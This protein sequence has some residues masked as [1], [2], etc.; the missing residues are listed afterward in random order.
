MNKKQLSLG[1]VG[2]VAPALG[3]SVSPFRRFAVSLYVVGLLAA[4]LPAPAQWVTQSISLKSGW[5]AVYLHV[6]P[7]YDTLD[8]QIAADASD[9]IL[10]V[11]LWAPPASTLQFVQSPQQPVE[12]EQWRSWNRNTPAAATLHRLVANAAYLVRSATNYTWTIKGKPLPPAYQWTTTG[13]NF[14]GFPT[15]PSLPPTFDSFLS[16]VPELYQSAEIYQYPGGEL[17]TGNPARLY[18]LRTTKVNRGQAYWIRS[19]TFYNRYFAPFEVVLSGSSGVD[20]GDNLTVFNFRLRNLTSTNLTVNLG[21]LASETPPTGQS[22]IVGT[23][24]L[25]V[26]GAIN[27]TNLTY[28]YSNLTAGGAYNWTLS[29]QGLSGSEVE[30]VLGLNRT[31]LSGS[32]G[33]L[34]AG[35]LRLTDAL[36]YARVDLPVSAQ[37]ASRA[38]LWV[39]EASLSQVGQYLKSYRRDGHS[40]PVADTNG[41]YVVSGINTN[42]GVVPRSFPLRL[43]VHNPEAGAGPAVLL[44]RVF[45]GVDAWTN[46]VVAL[47]ESSLHPNLLKQARRISAAHLPWTETNQCWAFD[48]ALGQ[49]TNLTTTVTLDY[50]DRASNPFLHAYHPDHDNL[51]TAFRNQMPQGAESY[52]VQRQ[53]TLTVTPPASDAAAFSGSGQTLSGAYAETI[54]VLGLAR[55]GGA[56]DQRVFEARGSFSL[57]RISTVPTLTQP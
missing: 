40:N 23:P 52:T 35:V 29:A 45:V 43:I 44:K 30:V 2:R 16:K 5:N 22:N 12:G 27:T 19:G 50:A 8:N 51:D 1:M 9:P 54:T 34:F 47:A 26:R 10:E 15:V 14:L 20:Y 38:G 41:Q 25:L 4:A 53:I 55:A 39:G 13:L 37:V 56:Y 18:A 48:G 11:W 24:S 36:G 42:L 17:G 3:L 21:L 57:N 6:D 31:A 46:P 49:A 33:D 7:S 32:V 28:S